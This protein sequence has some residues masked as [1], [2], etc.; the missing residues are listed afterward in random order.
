[1]GR[2]SCCKTTASRKRSPSS[3]RTPMRDGYGLST[4]DFPDDANQWSDNDGDGFGDNLG[5]STAMIAPTPPATPPSD[6]KGALTATA[7]ALRLHRR[8]SPRQ[9][10]VERRRRRRLRRQ[11]NGEFSGRLP[12]D[13]GASNRDRRGCPDAD[14][15]GF[16][17]END[18]I[19][20]TRRSGRT[21]TKMATATTRWAWAGT[22]AR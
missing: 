11:P 13:P 14:G 15:D 18:P 12:D 1:M 9:H 22:A 6:G 8:V 4:D 10:P 21:P 19:R 2:C 16:S 3:A 20:A 7:T 17:D 5:F